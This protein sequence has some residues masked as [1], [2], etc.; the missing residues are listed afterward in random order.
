MGLLVYQLRCVKVP[1]KAPAWRARTSSCSSSRWTTR[2]PVYFNGV[3]V[4]A[5]GTFPPRYRSGL[6]EA[7]RHRCLRSRSGSAA[8]HRRR[9]RLL[10]RRPQQ[11][12]R[13]RAGCPLRQGGDPAG[14]DWQARPLTTRPGKG[15]REARGSRRGG[16]R[17]VDKVDDVERYVRRPQGDHDPYPPAEAPQA[18]S[19]SRPT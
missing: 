4:G 18:L 19:R 1:G 3:Q 16:L 17:R 12:Q 5:A 2:G 14:G 11:L 10:L 9:A 13:R 6:G 15:H 8:E 7:S